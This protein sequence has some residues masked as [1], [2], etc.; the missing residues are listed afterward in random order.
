[1]VQTS[2]GKNESCANASVCACRRSRKFYVNRQLKSSISYFDEKNAAVI[3][4]LKY[5]KNIKMLEEGC[6]VALQQ[7]QEKHYEDE[8]IEEGYNHI[9]EY[10]IC[11]NK[12]N[13]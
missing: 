11:F 13:H 2:C 6:D 9:I 3:M 7:I 5:A 10:G 4:E 12:K 8:L 1:M